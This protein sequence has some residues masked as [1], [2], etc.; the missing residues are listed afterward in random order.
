[1][2][3]KAKRKKDIRLDDLIEEEEEEEEAEK[4]GRPQRVN[5]QDP[6]NDYIETLVCSK[7][8]ICG[9]L[10]TSS[11]KISS[12]LES[13]HLDVLESSVLSSTSTSTSANTNW[14]LIAQKHQIPL[15]CPL[16]INTFRGTH[17]SFKVHLMDDH[18]LN[19]DGTNAHYDT[20]NEKRR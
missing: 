13:E 8:K 20:Q 2:G 10:T 16:C 4:F 9:Y 18:S 1:M 19:E 5:K 3:P 14:L 15:R 12:H 6:N 17:L 11:E 7:C